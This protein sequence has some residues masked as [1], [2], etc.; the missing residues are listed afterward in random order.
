MNFFIHIRTYPPP[1]AGRTLGSKRNKSD[2]RGYGY[3]RI[4][5]SDCICRTYIHVSGRA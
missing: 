1:D 4:G 5:T 2:P 3:W